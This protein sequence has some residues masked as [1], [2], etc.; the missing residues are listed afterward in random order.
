MKTFTPIIYNIANPIGFDAEVYTVQTKLARIPWLQAIFGLAHVQKR[1][2]SEGESESMQKIGYRGSAR[3]EHY[4]PQ[5]IKYGVGATTG[6]DEDLS[7][8]DAYASRIFFL[9][10]DKIDL[11]PK[12]DGWNWVEQNVLIAQNFS[13]ILH[14]NQSQLQI[15]SYEQIK[16]D[17]LY[18]LGQC[19]KIVATA[20]W[21]NMDNVWREFTITPEINGCTRYPNY[22][23]RIDL[24]CTYLAFPYNGA[25]GY[26]PST[27]VMPR[28]VVG[29]RVC[30]ITCQIVAS[31]PTGTQI[32]GN[33]NGDAPADIIPL[34]YV[35]NGD[36][37][38]TIPYLNS[39]FGITLLSRFMLKERY[40][41]GTFFVGGNINLSKH[42]GLNV[43]DILNF[44]ASIPLWDQ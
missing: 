17:I 18:A 40:Y 1:H 26:Y 32:L 39:V 10:G 7:F 30:Q 33:A 36:G 16:T 2:K 42:G 21:E 37:T 24:I 12:V 27:E 3:Y 44:D 15:S 19:P 22:C 25:P 8:D 6:P 14:C 34:Q 43:G 35:L 29:W 20:A 13:L 38:V 28:T 11:N 31:N 5:G 23:L 9:S 41:Q 4:Y